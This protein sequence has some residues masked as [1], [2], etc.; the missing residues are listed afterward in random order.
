MAGHILSGGQP[1][2][3]PVHTSFEPR[4]E[5]EKEAVIKELERILG[6]TVFRNSK[7]YAAVLR[8]IVERTLDGS[9]ANLK[10]RT[11]GIEVFGRAPDYDTASDHVVRSAVAEIRKRLAQYYQEDANGGEL[12]IEVQPGSYVPQFRLTP[13]RALPD[14]AEP[15]A[16]PVPRRNIAVVLPSPARRLAWPRLRWLAYSGA[17]LAAVA[18]ALFFLLRPSDALDSFWGPILSARN[19]VLL[20]IGNLEG[21]H[22]SHNSVAPST[23]LTVRDFHQLDSQI[24]HVYDAMTLLRIAGLMQAKGKLYHSASQSEANFEDLQSG[25]AVLVGLMNNDWTERL[26]AKLRFTV[27]HPNRGIIII[28]DHNNPTRDDW[29]MDYSAPFM[30]VTKDY[31]LVLRVRDPKTDQMVVA[32]A[33]ISVLGTL[34]AGEFLTNASEMQKLAAVAPKGWEQKNMEIVLSTDVIQGRPGHATIVATSFW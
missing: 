29:S 10:E 28:R 11:I 27:E 20:C 17:A 13:D 23:V 5:Q 16:V 12:R 14:V 19:P 8:Y 30:E 9:D 22:R 26:V 25:P 1:T 24:V 4:R 15:R 32:V 7:R 6:S 33:G 2:L 3:G 34:A 18:A 31:A 21:G